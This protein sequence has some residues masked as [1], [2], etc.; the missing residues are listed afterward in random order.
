MKHLYLLLFCVCN[1]LLAQKQTSKKSTLFIPAKQ[2]IQIDYPYYQGYD[3]QLWNK[4]KFDL[5]V[6]ARDKE[7]DSLRKGFGL[8]KGAKATLRV[9][10]SQYVQLENRFLAPQEVD[11]LVYKGKTAKKQSGERTPQRGFYLVNNTVQSIPLRIPGVMNPNLS[12]FSKSGVDLPLGQKILL[13][14]NGKDIEILTV[15]DT[16][17]RGERVDVAQLID[18]ALN[19]KN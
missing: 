5:G 3:I 4:S 1:F 13:R 18:K 16:I 15:T 14:V 7:T 11:Y 10:K 2:V 17:A 19:S 6:S 8:S 12:P 9:D